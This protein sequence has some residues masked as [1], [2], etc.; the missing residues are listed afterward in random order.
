[1]AVAVNAPSETRSPTYSHQST[2]GA[3]LRIADFEVR[4]WIYDDAAEERMRELLGERP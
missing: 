3:T 1:M 2:A 4:D